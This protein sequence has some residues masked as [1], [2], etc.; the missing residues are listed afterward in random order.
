M[1]TKMKVA[2]A[3]AALGLL[4]HWTTQAAEETA[5]AEAVVKDAEVSKGEASYPLEPAATT[6][7]FALEVHDGKTKHS[8]RIQEGGTLKFKNKSKDKDL[9]IKAKGPSAPFVDVRGD[10]KPRWD[11][12]IPPGA[13]AS[14]KVS[15]DY[16]KGDSFTYSSR[17]GE[18]EEDDPIVII[19]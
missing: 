18:S 7:S 17:I 12:T 1:N 14:V 4:S 8:F 19:E 9:Q 15:G 13:T 10:P 3:L 6:L 5:Q 2:A 11:V 16:K